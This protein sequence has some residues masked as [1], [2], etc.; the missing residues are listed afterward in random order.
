M[1]SYIVPKFK[2]TS[3]KRRDTT[4]GETIEQKFTRMMKNGEK[5]EGGGDDLMYT[6]KKDGVRPEYNIRTDRFA[7]AQDG[8]ETIGA[9]Y[10]ARAAQREDLAK[11]EIVKKDDEVEPTQ[12]TEA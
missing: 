7:I 4:E 3:I 8:V 11:M 10:A 1:K 12:G 9:S 2:K 6:D 5:I